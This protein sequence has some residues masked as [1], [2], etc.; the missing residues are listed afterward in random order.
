MGCVYR[1][2][3][4]W[5]IKYQDSN[6]EAAYEAT[7]ARTKSQAKELLREVEERAFRERRGLE[8]RTLNPEGW[9][10]ADLMNW[11]LTNYSANSE[12]HASNTGTVRNHILPSPMAAK[13]LE[14]VGP[15]DV[16][17]LL[18]EKDRELSPGTVNHVRRFLVRAFNKAR[19]AQKWLGRNPAQETETR[20]VPERIASILTPEE[21]LPFFQALVP[22]QRPVFATAILAG[23]RKGEL[24]GLQKSDVDLARRLL[25][26]RRS[27][28]RPST[29]NMKQRV[30]RIPDELVPF[31][32]QAIG[33]FPGPWL[34]PDDHGAMRTMTWQPEDIL[35]RALKRAGIVTGY[36]HKCRRKGCGHE[37]PRPDAE[38]RRCPKCNFLLWPKAHVRAIRFHDLRHTYAS[39]LLMLGANLVSVQKLL[40]HS[41]PTITERRYGHLLPDFMAAEVNKLRFGLGALATVPARRNSLELA[42]NVP[43][44]VT[45][46]LQSEPQTK[47]EAESPPK[48]GVNSA[49]CV[50]RGTGFEPVAFGSGGRR[51]IQLS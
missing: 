23:L 8:P 20:R 34:F 42:A 22:E 30:V 2:G 33:E 9:T 31:L 51:S 28:A 10:V 45:P 35:R 11:W 24:C 12:S 14:R 25:F 36:T 46:G 48:P 4:V 49:S 3:R 6:D 16:E 41:D 5:W 29:K 32:E 39:V 27:Y 26:V 13:R 44:A 17:R 50:A 40:G 43:P 21:V 15:G 47:K 7:P 38:V 18:N 37:E 19:K 1:R